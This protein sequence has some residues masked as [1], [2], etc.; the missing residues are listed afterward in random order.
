MSLQSGSTLGTTT[1]EI[2][3][4]RKLQIIAYYVHGPRI[5]ETSILHTSDIRE[6]GP[7]GFIVDTADEIMTLDDSLVRLNEVIGF[8]FQLLGKQVIDDTKKKLGKVVE[9]TLESESFM[10]QKLH[11][12]QNLLKNIKSS[13]LIIHRSQIIEINDKAVIVRSAT[14]EATTSFVQAINPFRKAPTQLAPERTNTQSPSH[15]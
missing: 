14:A 11:V 9:Y 8:H 6:V 15:K 7:L 12:S 13:S 3:D 5:T 2:I 4:P 10:I 1:E